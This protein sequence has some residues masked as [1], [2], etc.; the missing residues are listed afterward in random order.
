[1]K[2]QYISLKLQNIFL[3]TL[4]PSLHQPKPSF[5]GLILMVVYLFM[6]D[7]SNAQVAG[8]T[9]NQAAGTHTA[10]TG[11]T[12]A[13]S[14]NW[15]DDITIITI[16][17][18][19]TFNSIG[20]TSCNI[21]T[22][23]FITF[24]ATAP[25]TT[26]YLPISSTAGYAGAISVL[27]RDLGHNGTR[28]QHVTTGTTPNRVLTV[29]WIDAR[30]FDGG[31][32]VN[33]DFD[34]Q[35]KLYE[36]SNIVQVVYGPCA[37]TYTTDL[38]VQVGL[39]GAANTDFN[40]RTTTNNWPASTAGGTNAATCNTGNG[41]GELPTGGLTYT[42]TPP[43][44]VPTITS[45][46]T[47]N[48]CTGDSL[49]INGTN[50]S[51]ATAV[52]IGGTAATIT[53]NTATTVTV[54]VGSGTTGTVAVTT[55]G[56]TATSSGTYTVSTIPANPANPT[57]N[58]P[59]C[60]PTGVTITQTGAAPVGQTWYWQTTATGT[61][62]T[63]NAA[64]AQVVSTSGTY[65]IRS[66]NGTCWSP[67]SGS[68]V[69]T[70]NNPIATLATIPNPTTAATGVCYAGSGAVTTTSWTAAAGATSYDVYFGTNPVP[71]FTVN[72]VG[73]TYTTGTLLASTTYYWK[74]VPKSACGDT[75]G[76][77]IVWSFTTASVP[78]YCPPVHTGAGCLFTQ[79]SNVTFNTLNNPSG[80]GNITSNSYNNYAATGI[81][82][83]TVTRGTTYPLS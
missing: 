75:S 29:Q 15:D 67:S 37:T 12:N 63:S 4:R 61:S 10:I 71:V 78:C 69:V 82:T 24:G 20:Y 70:V 38:A 48:G 11:G 42:W 40:N 50:L 23:G 36:T 59:Q 62:T 2:Q 8:Y 73:T 16:P 57:S 43:A 33:N 58:S 35:I 9:F 55:S 34:F 22:N 3:N 13:S 47:S 41:A 30:R 56:G 25:A 18:T 49:I 52:T 19:F 65:Y 79:I 6:F 54:T 31:T 26:N 83:T 53:G 32:K 74:I 60:N 7:V 44:L 68:V 77:P 28:V 80:C 17:F 27:A 5:L 21:S 39:R 66:F 46:T 64:T 1:M 14:N 45:L 81:P 76:T 72:Q 51:S